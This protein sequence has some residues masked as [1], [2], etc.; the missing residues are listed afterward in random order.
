[1]A[2]APPEPPAASSRAARSV[3]PMALLEPAAFVWCIAGPHIDEQID[4]IV[5]RKQRDIE[6]FGW[7]LWSYGGIRGPAHPTTQ[8]R[9]L[10][11]RYSNSDVLPLLMPI[12]GKAWPVGQRFT[13]YRV[14]P[15]GDVIALPDGM[16]PVTGGRGAWA[17]YL[18]DLRRTDDTIDVGAY[19]MPFGKDGAV[20]LPQY[21]RG[22]HGRA[23]SAR[24]PDGSTAPVADIRTVDLIAELGRPFAVFLA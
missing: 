16:S 23:C 2:L 5:E 21:L 11:E 17:F 15:G 22:S 10:A 19:V 20:P 6:Q 18:T 9:P 1:M 12:K 4:G 7:C 13:G 8:V 3:W 14:E 24:A